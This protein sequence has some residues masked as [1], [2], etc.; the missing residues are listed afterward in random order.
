[1][2]AAALLLATQSVAAP[3]VADD[4]IVW[5]A[6]GQTRFWN[7]VLMQAAQSDPVVKALDRR[8]LAVCLAFSDLR[9]RVTAHHFGGY[10]EK[11]VAAFR[12]NV[13]PEKLAQAVESGPSLADRTIG[14]AAYS[15]GLQQASG[16][17]RLN[18]ALAAAALSEMIG[19][20]DRRPLPASIPGRLRPGSLAALRSNPALLALW[21]ATPVTER[22]RAAGGY[23]KEVN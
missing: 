3:A 6:H 18:V 1:M 14:Y 20:W 9:D 11:L 4:E 22:E 5:I 17:A 16:E 8:G 23:E 19:K 13:P 2:M 10:R 15:R 21:C 12:R 7:E